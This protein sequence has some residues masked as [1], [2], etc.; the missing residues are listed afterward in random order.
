MNAST[1]EARK[2]PRFA[3]I[4]QA[5]VGW[6]Y[7][8]LCAACESPLSASRQVEVP[9]L[10]EPCE[11]ALTPIGDHYCRVC[12]QGFDG[13][14]SL[15][16]RCSNCGDRE[17]AID[18]AVSAFRGAG[19]GKGLVHRFKYAKE[20]HLARLF[21]VL[22]DEVWRDE[23]LRDA[24]SWWVVPVPL[25]RRRQRER[26]FN[27][28]HELAR[29]LVLRAPEGVELSLRSLLRR[30]SERER[31]ARL[32]RKERLVNLSEAFA[33]V[34]RLPGTPA[35]G[36]RILLIDDVITTGTTVSECAAVLREA[37]EIDRIA[38]VSVLRG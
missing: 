22:L 20:R 1:G 25:H 3:R 31:Q 24:G 35:G 7:P 36:A 21:G 29:E 28:S 13:V 10:C 37:M 15:P 19:A 26:G 32:D 2:S 27:Q 33:P 6:I 5:V 16:F 11:A 38:A 23:R 14:S 9:F 8:P 34:R 4:R 18:F 30:T 12:G 17:L